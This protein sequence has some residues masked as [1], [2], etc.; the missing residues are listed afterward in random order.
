MQLQLTATG[1]AV[2]DHCL[3][4]C[5]QINKKYEANRFLKMFPD[6]GKSVRALNTQQR[7]RQYGIVAS[8][9]HVLFVV[10]HNTANS[11]AT[12]SKVKDFH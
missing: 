1:L 7:K 12:I 6:S 11:A 10:D 2:E 5:S 3:S 4:K 8:L 9:T